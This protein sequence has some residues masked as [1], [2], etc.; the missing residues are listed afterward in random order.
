MAKDD[1]YGREWIL[2]HAV[3]IARSYTGLTLR[4]L[5][6]RLVAAGFPNTINHYKRLGAAMTAARW[7]RTIRF[8]SFVDRDRRMIGGTLYSP[9]DVDSAVD[10]AMEDVREAMTSYNKRRWEN[11]DTYL[12]SWIEK[13][14]LVSVFQQ[15]VTGRSVG[16]GPCKG[17]PSLT[18]LNEA[19]VRFRMA[20][21]RGKNVVMLY[22]GDY[23]PSGQ[24]IPRSIEENLNR[25]GCHITVEHMM[26][27]ADQIE[28]L[29]LPGVPAKYTDSR[30]A[31]WDGASCVELDAVEPELLGKMAREHIMEYLDVD[32]WTELKKQETKERKEFVKRMKNEIADLDVEYNDDDEEDDEDRECYYCGKTVDKSEAVEDDDGDAYCNEECLAKS[33]N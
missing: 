4:Q 3:P 32:K 6:Y 27:H 31:N 11:Q 24:D 2:E 23:D 16:L 21:A 10:S 33:G 28:E 13:N 5:Y 25:M 7:D 20:K 8:D 1:G 17:Y 19:A 30:T 26:L 29:D 18:F 14:A 15:P 12:E 22:Y 9:T